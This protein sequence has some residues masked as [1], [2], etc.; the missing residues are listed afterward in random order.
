MA[1]KRPKKPPQS[2]GCCAPG[3]PLRGPYPT[4]DGRRFCGYHRGVSDSHRVHDITARI[5]ENIPLMR[6]VRRL[7]GLNASQILGMEIVPLETGLDA[8]YQ[9]REPESLE[10]WRDRLELALNHN[11]TARGVA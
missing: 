9:R 5:H 1:R 6:Q 7:H 10:C 4:N 3:C 2:P 8:A 11:I